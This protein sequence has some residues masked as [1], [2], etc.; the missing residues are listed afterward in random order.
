MPNTIP[1]AGEAMPIEAKYPKKQ[2]DAL[3]EAAVRIIRDNPDLMIDT[4]TANKH[5]IYTTLTIPGAEEHS[6]TKARRLM[7]ELSDTLADCDN[8]KWSAHVMPPVPPS[9]NGFASFP[10]RENLDE[11][12]VDHV[13][14][15]SWEL[16]DA[17]TRYQNGAFQA[18]VLPS[19]SAGHTVML[20]KVGVFDLR[21]KA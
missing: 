18:V 12:P 14:R 6:W 13:E 16:S 15:L 21:A 20:T 1:A 8:A 3:L 5:G 2:L 9:F 19:S 17:L 11:L 10:M 7:K 4:A